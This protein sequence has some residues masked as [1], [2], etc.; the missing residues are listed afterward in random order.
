[1]SFFAPASWEDPSEL[2]ATEA[3][4]QAE[5]E[6][7]REEAKI[8]RRLSRLNAVWEG[9]EKKIDSIAEENVEQIKKLW[10]RHE[11]A[12]QAVRKFESQ[13]KEKK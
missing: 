5:Y 8:K 4:E 13:M 6:Q 2:Y 9:I 11:A 1:M 7:E 3:E 10:I 12:F